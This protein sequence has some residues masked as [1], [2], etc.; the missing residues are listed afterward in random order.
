M[1]NTSHANSYCWSLKG[2]LSSTVTLS[3]YELFNSLCQYVTRSTDPHSTCTDRLQVMN[4]CSHVLGGHTEE[5]LQEVARVMARPAK[6]ETEAGESR[7]PRQ[8]VQPPLSKVVN[9]EIWKALLLPNTHLIH[10][11]T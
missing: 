4:D 7:L 5:L 3:S 2:L 10:I 1:L 11:Y 6:A 9:N 8:A